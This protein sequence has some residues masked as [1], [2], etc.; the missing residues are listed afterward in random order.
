M[1]STASEASV[2]GTAFQSTWVWAAADHPDRHLIEDFIRGCFFAE[3]QA[4]ICHFLTNLVCLMDDHG[5]HAAVGFSGALQRELYLEQYLASPVVDALYQAAGICADRGGII[6]VGNLA[7]SSPGGARA[8]VLALARCF[9]E[10]GAEWAVFTGVPSL[11]NTFSRLGIPM[12]ELGEAD[13][14]KLK[15][16]ETDWGTYY[17]GHPRVMAVSVAETF[18]RIEASPVLARMMARL[19]RLRAESGTA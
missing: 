13:P 8:V 4:R 14:E 9:H 5:I 15:D 16:R 17:L 3:Y 2:A 1:S 11:L 18:G 12:H 19:P 7:A 10:Q 6:E